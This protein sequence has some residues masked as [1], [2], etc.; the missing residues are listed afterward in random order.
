MCQLVRSLVII[1]NVL[2]RS[3]LSNVKAIKRE[4][5]ALEVIIKNMRRTNATA[6][7][8]DVLR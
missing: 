4:I 1:D 8:L 3:Q 2:S 5:K 7:A 6:V